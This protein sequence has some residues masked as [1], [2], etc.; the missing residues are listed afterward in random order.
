MVEDLRPEDVSWKESQRIRKRWEH[1]EEIRNS[2]ISDEVSVEGDLN[3]HF[4]IVLNP[5]TPHSVMWFKTD[6][7]VTKE[8][9]F[10]SFK[11]I[12][13]AA[14]DQLMICDGILYQY[15]S[16]NGKWLKQRWEDVVFEQK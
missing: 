14:G 3:L 12:A 16:S 6:S 10:D 11:K 5:N 8:F 2:R 7:K 4:V 9:V 13:K 1:D 15:D